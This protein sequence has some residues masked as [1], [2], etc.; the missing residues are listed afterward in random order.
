MKKVGEAKKD[1]YT[2]YMKT[3]FPDKDS[4][5]LLGLNLIT[6]PFWIFVL[7]QAK[8]FMD[9]QKRKEQNDEG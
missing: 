6:S 7:I 3:T 9:R 1:L 2:I 4:T 8:I 5:P